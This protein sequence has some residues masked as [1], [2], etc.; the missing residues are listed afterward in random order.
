MTFNVRDFRPEDAAAVAGIVRAAVPYMV[1]T[2]E[3]VAWQVAG[4]P[5]ARRYRFLVADK[6]G[7]LA[8]CGYQPCATERR[9]IRDLGAAG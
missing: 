3:G 8:G 1:T 6:G 5:A 7:S 2:P 4:A 9:Y